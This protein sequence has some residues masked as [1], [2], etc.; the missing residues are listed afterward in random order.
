MSAID[1]LLF[2][3]V[4]FKCVLFKYLLKDQVILCNIYCCILLIPD[5]HLFNAISLYVF[6]SV[7]FWMRIRS[8][9]FLVR[10]LLV[11]IFWECS[12]QL[13]VLSIYSI[14]VYEPCSAIYFW[15]K[16]K[17]ETDTFRVHWID[18]EL[19]NKRKFKNYIFLQD[20]I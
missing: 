11:Q 15:Q 12:F 8:V 17:S 4:F 13:H 6:I 3:S 18:Y 16:I 2:C 5:W 19:K 1:C 9:F 10:I 14:C 7:C 20:I